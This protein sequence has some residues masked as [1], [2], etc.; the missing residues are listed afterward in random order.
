M[1]ELLLAAGADPN[2]AMRDGRRPLHFAAAFD[3]PAAVPLLL[4]AGAT[5][6]TRDEDGCTP[7]FSASRDVAAL[8]LAAGADVRVRDREGNVPFHRNWL[9]VL[10]APGVNVRN[11]AGLTPLHFAA[12]AGN[13]RA[14]Q[15]LLAQGA[16]PSATTTTPT[17][18]RASF[19]SKAFGPGDPV[20]AGARPLDLA[21]A[22]HEQ[23]KWS[24]GRYRAT[25]EALEEATPRR[26]WFRR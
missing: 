15:W 18:W 3:V 8:L 26:G 24:S 5:V 11:T 25:L 6:D 20:P 16:H 14:V 22:Q 19:M 21:R 13:E 12:L 23:T 7:L 9:P 17:H 10:Q 2:A 4:A 1:V